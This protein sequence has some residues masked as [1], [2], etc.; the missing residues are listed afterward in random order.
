MKISSPHMPR[1]RSQ[2]ILFVEDNLVKRWRYED[3]SI[4]SQATGASGGLSSAELKAYIEAPLK[5]E[6]GP[7][8]V[9]VIARSRGISM[10]DAAAVLNAAR[11]KKTKKPGPGILART[12]KRLKL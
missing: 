11:Y 7:H 4:K 8:C 10:L 5:L 1:R 6:A 12:I 2:G 3:G 9:A